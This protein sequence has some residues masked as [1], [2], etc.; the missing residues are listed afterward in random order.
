MTYSRDAFNCRK[1]PQK[2]GEGGCPIW[3]ETLHEEVTT[4]E[5]KTIKSCGFEQ[6]PMYL[7]QVIKAANG[8]AASSDA[9][10]NTMVSKFGELLSKLGKMAESNPQIEHKE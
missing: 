2:G 9:A 4:G 10:R 5:I 3:W 6:L 1:C 7:V 8:M